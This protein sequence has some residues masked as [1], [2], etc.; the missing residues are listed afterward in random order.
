MYVGRIPEVCNEALAD[1]CNPGCGAIRMCRAALRR[2]VCSVS[3]R[4]RLQ[5]A[6]LCAGA[7]GTRLS[8]SGICRAAGP[9]PFRFR[10]LGRAWRPSPSPRQGIRRPSF[11]GR[12]PRLATVAD[13]LRRLPHQK[14]RTKGSATNGS[15]RFMAINCPFNLPSST[16]LAAHK[17]RPAC[18][19]A[20]EPNPL[21]RRWRRRDK[22]ILWETF[23]PPP[24]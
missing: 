12:R 2:A 8:G 5:P 14:P 16:H 4:A 9:V 13:S 6:V 19:T 1:S 17:K 22:Y 23:L 7:R 21:H 15:W 24:C 10:L 3:G 11:P 20:H 18:V